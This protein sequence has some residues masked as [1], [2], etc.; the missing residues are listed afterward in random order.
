MPL[1]RAFFTNLESESPDGHVEL[2]YLQR[3]SL[4][5]DLYEFFTTIINENENE[6]P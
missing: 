6:K 3:N 1:V 5:H 4:L 2:G